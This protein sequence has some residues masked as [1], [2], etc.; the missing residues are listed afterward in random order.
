MARRG[1]W[2][3]RFGFYLIAIGS[4]FGLGNLWRFPYVVGENGGGAFVLLYVLMAFVIGLPLLVSELVLGKASRKSVTVA[5][6]NLNKKYSWIG[7]LC[8][9]L[10][11]IVLS[12]YSVISGWVLHYLTQFFAALISGQTSIDSSPFRVLTQNLWLQMLLAS[13]HLLMCLVVVAQ[14][15]Q[16]GLEKWINY[17]MP[18]F[19]TLVLLLVARSLSLGGTT[20]VLRFL[21]YPDF[22]KL[23][24][25]SLAEALG[26]VFFTLSVGFGTMVT[27]GSYMKEDDHAPTMGYRVSVVDT[28]VSL[29]SALLVFPLAFT[30]FPFAHQDPSLV[31]EVL[32]SFLLSQKG[33]L[34]FG[35]LFFACFY[36]AALNASLG[37]LEAIVS[38]FSDMRPNLK[39]GRAAW[40]SGAICF[41]L[42]MFGAAINFFFPTLGGSGS[43]GTIALVDRLLVN[44]ALPITVLIFCLAYPKFFPSKERK[45]HFVNA[46]RLVSGIMYPYWELMIRW[47]I[48]AVICFALFLQTLSLFE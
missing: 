41:V 19:A 48:P 35:T 12:Y 10:S 34:I 43:N 47:V 1:G 7:V 26:H 22:S 25:A 36:M 18:L 46:D 31:F 42:I 9:T 32:P 4:A 3:T 28:M 39:R 20:E 44:W 6:R 24:L 27:F 13:A 16:E 40:L 29:I 23:Q 11:L 8:V 2:R 17:V 15:V 5:I 38:N 33:G 14:G 30:V 21:F 37:L 45:A